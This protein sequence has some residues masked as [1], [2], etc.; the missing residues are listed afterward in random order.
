MTTSDDQR[1]L[2]TGAMGC[3]GAW[4]I[5]HLLHEGVTV[6]AYDLPGS[7]HRLDLV[8]S[9]GSQDRV[10]FIEGD[11]NNIVDLEA[12]V[13]EN[14][15]THII[16]LAALQVPFVRRDPV[17]GA[18][19]N[20][21]GT[22]TVLEVV[23]RHRPQVRG[24]AYASS[25]A[26]WGSA[27]SYPP[28]P[29]SEDAR[30]QP[31]TL[32]G[33]FKLANEDTARIYW[34]DYQVPSIGLRPYVVYGPGRD[35]GMT[36][37]PSK[38]ILAAAVG[39]PYHISLAGQVG[40]EYAPD[41]AAIFVRAAR[42]ASVGSDVFDLGGRVTGMDEVV[43]AIDAAAPEMRSRITYSAEPASNVILSGRRLVDKLGP[44]QWTPLTEGIAQ[45]IDLFRR[46]AAR[47]VIDVDRVLS[48]D[49]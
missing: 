33:V 34:Q 3:I 27:T 7:R 23:R 46:G 44:V 16:H 36:S 40:F 21:A 41:V 13:V 5:D 37:S 22:T 1:F 39:R 28:G 20:V 42:T 14:G 6:T 17:R 47:G 31:A 49:A 25:A 30:P 11:V 10:T 24:L 8:T 19:V 9:D 4:T 48:P 43:H 35:Q 2:V 15:I 38:G 29:L 32:Y 45:S 12:A 18:L 26:V